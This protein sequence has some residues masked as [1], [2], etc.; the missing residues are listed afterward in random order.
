MSGG[1][2]VDAPPE[3]L[4]HTLGRHRPRWE[5]PA[6]GAPEGTSRRMV[7]RDTV[8]GRDL[9]LLRVPFGADRLPERDALIRTLQARTTV[10][11][12]A[13]VAVH[14][15]GEWE[16]DAFVLLEP[17]QAPLPIAEAIASLDP[18]LV[19]RLRW[20]VSLADAARVLDR[21]ELA[22]SAQDWAATSIDAYRVPRVRGLEGGV[23]ASSDTRRA[24]VLALADLIA[25]L[26]PVSATDLVDRE[27]RHSLD[28]IARLARLGRLSI[29][30]IHER[31]A[32]LVGPPEAE[33][34]LL[35]NVDPES[36]RRREAGLLVA[37]LGLFL[38]SFVVLIV[39]LASSR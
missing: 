29:E 34:P 35:P 4:P 32:P 39:V 20:A 14:D 1:K 6:P 19:E 16:N 36:L 22:L 37:G 10:L 23:P 7:A 33:R 31:L 9:D 2:D 17:V 25:L 5:E 8:L 3:P 28:G 13:L 12:P 27:V 21:A 15:A 11:S 18:P 26:S 30:Q 38:L 24:T